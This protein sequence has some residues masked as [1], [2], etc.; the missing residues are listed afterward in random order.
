[1]R[2]APIAA[3]TWPGSALPVLMG[4][5]ETRAESLSL[6]ANLQGQVLLSVPANGA[7]L[8]DHSHLRVV[9]G[10]NPP[11]RIYAIWKN[12][13]SDRLHQAGFAIGGQSVITLDLSQQENWTG[14]VRSLQLGFRAFPGDPFDIAT[15]E[16]YRPGP[17]DKLQGL[18]GNWTYFRPWQAYDINVYTGTRE[19]SRGPYPMPTIGAAGLIVMLVYLVV[20]RRR[21]SWRAAAVILLGSWLAL[22]ALWQY[23]LWQQLGETRTR[24]AGLDPEQKLLASDDGALY[25]LAKR[26]REIIDRPDARIFIASSG[27]GPGMLTAYYVAPLNTYWHRSGQELPA[28]RHLHSG[29]FILRLRDSTLPYLPESGVITTPS[30]ENIDVMQHLADP[31][32]VLLEVR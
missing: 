18:L 26:A 12:D 17:L 23:R 20:A 8:D 9:F 30:G 15:V 14:A 13:H 4:S 27:D 32:G 1:M 11:S 16:L 19:F 21:F 25:S 24:Y 10:A 7:S 31:Q 5:A 2:C 6:T 28:A 22:D 3:D 29:D